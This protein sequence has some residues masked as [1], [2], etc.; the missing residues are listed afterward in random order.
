MADDVLSD[1]SSVVILPALDRPKG[2]TPAVRRKALLTGTDRDRGERLAAM[3]S[4]LRSAV[5]AEQLASLA[6]FVALPIAE[7]VASPFALRMVGAATAVGATTVH[8]ELRASLGSTASHRA[9]DLRHDSWE[10]GFLAA[11]KYEQ[12]GLEDPHATFHPSHTSKWGPHEL[13]H[14]AVGFFHR[15]APSRFELYLGARLNE[16]LPVVTWYGFEQAMRL[17]EGRFDR[18]LA[19]RRL[20]ASVEN[21]RWLVARRHGDAALE[22]AG[23][24]L[25]EGIEHF[26]RE[27]A[28]ID[29]ELASGETVRVAHPFLD[30]SS[31]A[32]GYV[33]GHAA[34]LEGEEAA[35]V[36]GRFARADI[37]RFESIGDYRNHIEAELDRLLFQ[38]IAID[39]EQASSLRD[40]RDLWDVAQRTARL[41]RK[42]Y[43]RAK[44]AIDALTDACDR[45]RRGEP[46][47]VEAYRG[48]L[49]SELRADGARVIAVGDARRAHGVDAARLAEGI[50]NTCSALTS[51][52]DPHALA[53]SLIEE[54]GLISR[55]SLP[56]RA[57]AYLEAARRPAL[58][59]A[60]RFDAA[61]ARASKGDSAIEILR[62]D[63]DAA[64]D[65]TGLVVAN[66]SFECVDLRYD[67]LGDTPER[68]RST[69]LLV[70]RFEGQ[71]TVIPVPARFALVSERL[72]RA[73]TTRDEAIALIRDTLG[74]SKSRARALLSVLVTSG[75]YGIRCA[76]P[77]KNH[78]RR[79]GFDRY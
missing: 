44:S 25:R 45:A 8:Q 60:A 3:A 46:V 47:D 2:R 39:L 37:E 71:I 68:R 50:T 63:S 41:G 57:S 4:A 59:D 14:R 69:A 43:R 11:G 22:L 26:E 64:D 58:A 65:E 66:R 78:R 23:A 49:A 73:P 10:N 77:S 62:A 15:G 67:V 33:A 9:S 42:P 38:P 35:D 53:L 52:V 72:L 12:F 79:R 75:A 56:D 36:L 28:A 55:A 51:S 7:I 34:F 17:D 6:S 1:G 30:A 18:E 27:L 61:I 32:L 74:L 20:I 29:R 54:D 24:L 21:A 19:G 76:R 13:L 40:G 5:S 48:R 70:G 16:L 31:D